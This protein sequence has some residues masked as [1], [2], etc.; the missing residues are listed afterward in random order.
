MPLAT[1][2]RPERKNVAERSMKTLACPECLSI[3]VAEGKGIHLEASG[4]ER[5]GKLRRRP[6]FKCE[7]CEAILV[8][9]TRLFG[10]YE[11]EA[12]DD[13]TR[14]AMET[15]WQS[16]A[17]DQMLRTRDASMREADQRQ[18]EQRVA[19]AH[20]QGRT[21]ECPYCNKFLKSEAGLDAHVAAVHADENGEPP[22]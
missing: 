7:E 19:R 9:R 3:G 17:D 22:A 8:V 16:Q 18:R 10:G 4:F 1:R 20:E 12:V 5:R 11:A 21:V 2:N 14:V 6:V 13:D 15:A